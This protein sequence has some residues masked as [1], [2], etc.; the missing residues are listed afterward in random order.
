MFD[1]ENLKTQ[2]C[3]QPQIQMQINFLRQYNGNLYEYQDMKVNLL[4]IIALKDQCR[5]LIIMFC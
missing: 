2:V 1:T 4:L 5:L 3:I